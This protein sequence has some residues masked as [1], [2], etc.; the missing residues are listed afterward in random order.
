VIDTF[1][2]L[3]GP[4]SREANHQSLSVDPDTMN[5]TSDTEGARDETT[6]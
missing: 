6:A 4:D 2:T 3:F 1:R 5:P